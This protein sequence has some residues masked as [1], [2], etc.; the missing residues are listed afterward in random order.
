MVKRREGGEVYNAVLADEN[1]AQPLGLR[2]IVGTPPI[3]WRNATTGI[4]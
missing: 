3:A 4:E 1:P 2:G